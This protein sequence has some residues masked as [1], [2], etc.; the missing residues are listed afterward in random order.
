MTPTK[1]AAQVRNGVFS[2][3]YAKQEAKLNLPLLP[4]TTIGSFPQTAE[5]RKVRRQ[6]NNGEL[7]D[8]DYQDVMKAEIRQCVT[9]QEE[10]GL[11]VLVHGEAER[12]DMVEYFAQYLDGFGWL[13]MVGYKAKVR[14][15]SVHQ[16]WLVTSAV[17]RQWPLTRLAM[18][19]A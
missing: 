2:D 1:S 11:D 5:I 15:V 7:S 3:R 17:Q 4:T 12:T 9:D 8:S 18:R 6:W 14:A 13:K 19:K 16:S 10:L